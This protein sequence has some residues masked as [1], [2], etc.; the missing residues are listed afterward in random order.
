MHLKSS[1]LHTHR[2]SLCSSFD[3]INHTQNMFRPCALMCYL[4]LKWQALLC[5]RKQNSPASAPKTKPPYGLFP[6]LPLFL[7]W[8]LFVYKI[9]C[10]C[11]LSVVACWPWLWPQSTRTFHVPTCPCPSSCYKALIATV[12]QEA[13]GQMHYAIV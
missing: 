10:P 6:A 5:F 9:L 12:T 1:M 2:L 7:M 8:L 3:I 11:D 13:R 4:H